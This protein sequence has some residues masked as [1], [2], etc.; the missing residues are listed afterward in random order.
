MMRLVK[1]S[2]PRTIIRRMSLVAVSV[3]QRCAVLRHSWWSLLANC[4]PG[5]TRL[6]TP[7]CTGTS[8]IPVCGSRTSVIVEAHE[9]HSQKYSVLRTKEFAPRTSTQADAVDLTSNRKIR[10]SCKYRKLEEQGGFAHVEI[11]VT[12]QQKSMVDSQHLTQCDVRP[13]EHYS[14]YPVLEVPRPSASKGVPSGGP[15]RRPGCPLPPRNLEHRQPRSPI[16]GRLQV[17]VG[18]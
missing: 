5:A 10:P 6:P 9:S 7:L 12:P 4:P 2:L 13:S 17:S 8:A 18:Q 14:C 1:S 15:G 3:C 16:H 11:T